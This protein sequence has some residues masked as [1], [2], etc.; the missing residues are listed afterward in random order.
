MKSISNSLKEFKPIERDLNENINSFD[1]HKW[2][3]I[4][5]RFKEQNPV[6][7]PKLISIKSKVALIKRKIKENKD[8]RNKKCHKNVN[9]LQ[10]FGQSLEMNNRL[11]EDWIESNKNLE[12]KI[13]NE[14]EFRKEANIVLSET[15]KK[16]NDTKRCFKK[17]N[18]IEKYRNLLK[19]RARQRNETI[20]CESDDTL[21]HQINKIKDLLKQ[22]LEM[23]RKEE[24]TI[25]N[26]LTIECSHQLDTEKDQ[27]LDQLNRTRLAITQ[28]MFGTLVFPEPNTS[29]A[30]N[31]WQLFEASHQSLQNMVQTRYLWDTYLDRSCGTSIPKHYVMPNNDPNCDWQKYL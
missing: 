7:E 6:L 22:R 31:N 24:N 26:M 11:I 18:S 19:G 30:L 2:S 13:E 8:K 27:T 25:N 4:I 1:D 17:I 14:I 23:Y 29:E 15:K 10:L 12:L 20:S 28:A 21:G 9:H 16:I 5:N 3:L